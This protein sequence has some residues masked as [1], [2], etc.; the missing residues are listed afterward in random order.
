MNFSSRAARITRRELLAGSAVLC[1]T[2]S[3]LVSASQLNGSFSP[4]SETHAFAVTVDPRASGTPVNPRILGSNVGWAFGGDNMLAP[5]GSFAP[6]MLAMARRLSPRV[7]RYPGGTYSDVFHWEA[8]DNE[9]VF[10]RQSLPTLMNTQRFLELCEAVGAEALITVN[11]VTG[12]L[13]EA[14]RWIKATNID[15][16]TSRI[17][18]R[19][20]PRVKFWEIG[21]EPYLKEQ[22]RSD[23]DLRPKE[24]AHRANHFIRALRQIDSRIAIGLP[25]TSDTRG[26]LPVTPY[27]GFTRKV[28]GIVDQDFDYVSVHNA[29][30]PFGVKRG[31]T[32]RDFYWGAAAGALTVQADLA[33]MTN[34]LEE[35]RP[36]RTLPIAVTEYSALFTLGAGATDGWISTPAGAIYLADVLRVFAEAPNLLLAAHWSLSANWLFGAIHADGHAR[37]SYQ[38]LQLMGEALKGDRLQSHVQAE[39]VRVR[40]VGQVAAVD[41]MPLVEVL[42]TR[43]HDSGTRVGRTMRLFMINKDPQRTA[44]GRLNLGSSYPVSARMS[45]LSA[46]DVFDSRDER[47]VLVRSDFAPNMG[48]V[49]AGIRL[50]PH[51]IALLTIE[52]AST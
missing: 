28:L 3:L 14:V 36:G 20:L 43:T 1:G 26:G 30:M 52:L 40:G 8:L 16:M 51:G 46:A 12:S 4:S 22:S 11:V 9:H 44:V 25:L 49:Q 39:S 13:E 15:G 37:P 10:S 24:F 35:I 33:A 2:P 38:V 32:P 5:D 29:Y 19:K 21:N 48:D 31:L 41:A 42:A 45:L 23:I 7:L 17:T 47:D 18:G 6:A 27:P 34:L 50:P